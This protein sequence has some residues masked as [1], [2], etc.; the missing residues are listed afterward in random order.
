MKIQ[1]NN[2]ILAVAFTPDGNKLVTGS[3]D[4]TVRIWK[5]ETNEA[6][7]KPETISRFSV[8]PDFFVAPV[9]PEISFFF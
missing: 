3:A 9:S 6:T 4:K 5:I 8:S 7:P 1:H 2:S